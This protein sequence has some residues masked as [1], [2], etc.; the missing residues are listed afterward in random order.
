MFDVLGCCLIDFDNAKVR[1][2][3]YICKFLAPKQ[4]YFKALFYTSF[5][6]SRER[7]FWISRG[8]TFLL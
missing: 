8:R 3:S 7:D 1:L 2:F 4:T 5:L 6:C